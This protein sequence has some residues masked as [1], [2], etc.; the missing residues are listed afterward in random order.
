M[1]RTYLNAFQ[2]GIVAGMRAM[3]APAFVSH[4][5]SHM[6]PGPLSDS[7][8]HFLTSTKT[9]TTLA[10]LAGGELVGDKLPSSPDR[11]KFPQMLGRIVS[12]ALSGA[13]LTEADD[14]PVA[15]GAV[16]G[17][18]GAVVGTFAFFHLRHWLTHEKG[19]PDPLVAVAEDA[20]TMGAGWLTVNESASL[21]NA[22]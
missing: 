14:E 12:G 16:L 19:L 20:L 8:L 7:P 9:A 3:S 4:K 11:T 5:L 1:N 13:A 2:I 6:T 22:F 21:R 18:L 15:S 10:V 17:A